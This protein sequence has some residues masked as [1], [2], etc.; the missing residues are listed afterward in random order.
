MILLKPRNEEFLHKLSEFKP[1]LQNISP[2]VVEGIEENGR[3]LE[4]DA[5]GVDSI[6]QRSERCRCVIEQPT[7]DTVMELAQRLE[8]DPAIVA[9]RV[10]KELHNYRL[11]THFVG[12]GEVQNIFSKLSCKIRGE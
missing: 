1:I 11:L 12:N 3:K 10:R 8:I 5:G 6:H 7:P 9:E 2:K 4:V